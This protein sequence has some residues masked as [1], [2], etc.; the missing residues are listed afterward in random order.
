MNRS[1]TTFAAALNTAFTTALTTPVALRVAARVAT[2]AA[3]R[4]TAR[5]GNRFDS[6]S[7]HHAVTRVAAFAAAGLVTLTIVHLITAYAYPEASPV[8]MA[9]LS[10][11][12]PR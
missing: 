5:L 11:V 2:R 3:A 4:L 12:N 10:A 9:Q 6:G 8:L 7:A 1:L